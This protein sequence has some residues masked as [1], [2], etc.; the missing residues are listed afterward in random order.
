[1][2]WAL[3]RM[4]LARMK[5]H[6]RKIRQTS[7]RSRVISTNPDPAAITGTVYAPTGYRVGALGT[8]TGSKPGT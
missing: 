4:M 1:M 6:L 8:M 2:P 3:S 7:F 5:A